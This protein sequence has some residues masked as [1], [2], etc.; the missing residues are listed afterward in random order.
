MPRKDL[1]LN[2]HGFTLQKVSGHNPVIL[3]VTYRRVSRCVHCRGK[4]LRK[5]DSFIR[6]VRHECFGL[7]R[8]FLRFKA[9]KFYCRR[10]QRYFN[11]RFP[12]ILRYQRATEKFKKQVFHHHSQGISQR[13]LSQNLKLGKSTVERWYQQIYTLKNKHLMHRACPKVLGIDEHTFSRKQGYVTTLCDLGKHRV[14]DV[15]TG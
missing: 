10:C 8:T 15:A 5:K 14:F 2:L 13:A 7:R 3:D 6:L 4:N 11:Q 9:H 1:I 12:G